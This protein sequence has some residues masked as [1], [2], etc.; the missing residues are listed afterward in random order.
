M[1][2]IYWSWAGGPVLIMRT[3]GQLMQVWFLDKSIAREYLKL[4][5]MSSE[6]WLR[7]LLTRYIYR[8]M[9]CFETTPRWYNDCLV[10]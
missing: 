8:I 7:V 5:Q 2:T 3:K 9:G 1:K 6:K 10:I 4:L